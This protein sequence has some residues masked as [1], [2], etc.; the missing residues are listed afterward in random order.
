MALFKWTCPTCKKQ[1]RKLLSERPQAIQL[2]PVDGDVLIEDINPSTQVLE[3]LDNGVMVRPLER[4]RDAV[5]LTK[6]HADSTKDKNNG[7]V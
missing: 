1:V 7:I 3:R 4:P 6:Q 5:E 2:C